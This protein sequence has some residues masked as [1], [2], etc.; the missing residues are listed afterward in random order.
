M[1]R[2]MLR[3]LRVSV[4]PSVAGGPFSSGSP[5]ICCSAVSPHGG[6]LLYDGLSREYVLVCG[7][8]CSW[9]SQCHSH[10][11]HGQ[12]IACSLLTHWLVVACYLSHVRCLFAA[13]GSWIG[14]RRDGTSV[15]TLF[16]ISVEDSRISYGA[17][18]AIFEIWL[19][20]IYC[21]FR[22]LSPQCSC[23]VVDQ[24]PLNTGSKSFKLKIPRLLSVLVP[25]GVPHFCRC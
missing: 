21:D 6:V 19:S 17:C 12:Q 24:C 1:V 16:G 18:T 4:G 8:G 5:Q 7:C 22:L 11:T 14:R 13:C 9:L 25:P 15:K 10:H 3:P 20:R 2:R 23:A